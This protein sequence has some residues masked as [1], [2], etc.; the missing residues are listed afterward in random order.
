LEERQL[1][2]KMLGRHTGHK[3]I[4]CSS[5]FSIIFQFNS[6][7]FIQP[8]ITISKFASK[9]FTI[10]TDKKSLSQDLTSDQEKLPMNRKTLSRGEKGRNL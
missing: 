10:C 5:N 8:I 7:Y 4:N 1:L 6:V 9:G 3:H 2:N